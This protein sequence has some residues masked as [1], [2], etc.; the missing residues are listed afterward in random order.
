MLSYT[1]STMSGGK[2][3]ALLQQRFNLISI[4]K[5]VVV[6]TSAL[7]N[8]YGLGKVTSRM[9]LNVMLSC[10][11]RKLSLRWLRNCDQQITCSSMK[12]SS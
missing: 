6:M 10:S 5:R 1:F 7:D 11:T 4:G 9:G 8:R 2:S 12:R 3:T